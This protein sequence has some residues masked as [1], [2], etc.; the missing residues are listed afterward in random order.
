MN[1]NI[2]AHGGWIVGA[3]EDVSVALPDTREV[4]ED[5]PS[6]LIPDVPMP[7]V[8]SVPDVPMPDDTTP[9]RAM[10]FFS[11]MDFS[12]FSTVVLKEAEKVGNTVLVTYAHC[13]C[14][15]GLNVHCLCIACMACIACLFVVRARMRLCFISFKPPYGWMDGWKDGRVLGFRRPRGCARE[16]RGERLSART[17]A[18]ACRF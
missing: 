12:P 16:Q 6:P 9:A 17:N 13:S 5:P 10:A 8:S 15:I 1:N 7:A 11:P 2:H 14:T 3:F 4:R 18:W